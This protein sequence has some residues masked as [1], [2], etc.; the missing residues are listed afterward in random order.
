M[1]SPTRV[2]EVQ[3]LFL[4]N[5]DLLRG[6]IFGL[7]PD[8]ALAEDVFQEVFLT[9]TRKARDFRPGSDFVAWVRTIARIKVLQQYDRRR[10]DPYVL[11][12]EVLDAVVSAA[13]EMDD[14]WEPRREALA[15]CLAGL[16]PRAQEMIGLR[17]AESLMPADIAERLS[18]T[19]GAVHVAL[20]RARKFL[21][22]CA[23]RRLATEDA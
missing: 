9:V 6:F 21:R 7:L 20:A 8:F 13:P 3:G 10:D 22:E 16:S 17:Y 2:E 1:C 18:W 4:R 23:Q 15:E 14:T 5:S 19:V 12:P 11:A